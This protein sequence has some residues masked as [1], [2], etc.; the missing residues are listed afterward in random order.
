MGEK[1]ENAMSSEGH[2]SYLKPPRQVV[3]KKKQNTHLRFAEKK[4]RVG[5]QTRGG[6]A[7]TTRDWG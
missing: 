4:E 6:E 5:S 3:A 2:T 1:N 7:I